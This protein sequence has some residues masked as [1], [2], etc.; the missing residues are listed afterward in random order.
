ML[1][2]DGT[3]IDVEGDLQTVMEEVHKVS[4]RREHTFAVL[5]DV[6]GDSIA[7]RPEA[8]LHVRELRSQDGTA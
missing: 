2:S 3:T 1:L 8:V 6:S 5:T 4:T 7:V